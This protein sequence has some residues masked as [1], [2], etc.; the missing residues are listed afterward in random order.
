MA[1]AAD[2][3]VRDRLKE[4]RE[5]L[6]S[7]R[8]EKK[9][10]KEDR[11]SA[12]TAFVGVNIAELAKEG[13]PLEELPEF[14]NAEEATKKLGVVEDQIADLGKA[15]RTIL[16]MLGED[17]NPAEVTAANDGSSVARGWNAERVLQGDSYKQAIDA[18]VFTSNSRFG[19]ISLGQIADRDEARQ[20]L[21][22]LPAAPAA[23][24]T[25]ADAGLGIQ[26]DYR[27]VVPPLLRP[28]RFLDLIP[29]GTT[30]SNSIE[31]VQVI[32]IPASA[33]PV[34]EGAVKPEQ[35]LTLQDATA[36]V[37]T[38]AGWIKVNR[39][40]M[41][42]VAGL[43]T[44]INT[45][46]PH[47]VRRQ[48]EFQVLRGDGTGQNLS[49]ILDQTGLGAPAFVSG[50]NTADAILRAMTV[51][52]L[53][54]ADP[55]FAAVHPIDWQNLLLLRETGGIGGSRAGQYLYGG[56][57]TMAAATVWGQVITPSTAITQGA[58]LVGDSMGVTLLYREGVNIKT[59]DSDQDDFIR[60][61]V[62]ILAEA[63]VAAPVWRPASFAVADATP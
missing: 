50:D 18:G 17:T 30:D 49:G 24:F 61:R 26:P 55:N 34:A 47:D 57:G 29:T 54:E 28:L 2:T 4:I 51:V 35:G 16:Q 60:N 5:N 22:E 46:L 37:R 58:P 36:P 44:L 11:D 45:L 42:D 20:Y 9:T 40:A 12:R 56:P 15:E 41:D 8:D 6:A 38:I 23:P 62:T 10:L 25:S 43:S 32:A 53:S 19:T 27:G 3:S 63:R 7:L 39:Q 48:I 13:K 31:Y 21:A 14:K 59:S 33:A 1:T 52:I